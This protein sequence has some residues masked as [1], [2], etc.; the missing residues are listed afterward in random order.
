MTW[1]PYTAPTVVGDL[2]VLRGEL[3]R[4]L[5]A[6][7][8]PGYDESDRRYPTLYLHDGQN[9][10]DR[11]LSNGLEWQV[12]ETLTALAAEGLELIAVGLPHA[13]VLRVHEYAGRGLDDHVRRLLDVKDVVE[14]TFRTREPAGVGGSSA[15]AHASVYA[16]ARH[17]RLFTRVLAMSPAFWADHDRVFGAVEGADPAGARIWLDVGGRESVEPAKNDAY[18]HVHRE[19]TELLRAH[20]LGDDLRSVVEPEAV[21]DEAAWAARLPAALRFLY[22]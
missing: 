3:D 11:D 9:L 20:G 6:W 16:W 17:P 15:G 21:H 8:P 12:D 7:V 10:F 1:R 5:Y 19:M 4:D 22:G 2:R 18:L 14:A 13:G